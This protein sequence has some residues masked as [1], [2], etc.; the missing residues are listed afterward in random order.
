MEDADD[1]RDDDIYDNVT[2]ITDNINSVSTNRT[3]HK[4]EAVND[5]VFGVDGCAGAFDGTCG[6][7]DKND[8]YD[9]DVGWYIFSGFEMVFDIDVVYAVGV[10]EYMDV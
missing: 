6:R 1:D 3:I 7:G 4:L 8:V 2:I 10:Y 5:D 9:V